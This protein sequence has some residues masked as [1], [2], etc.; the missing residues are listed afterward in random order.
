MIKNGLFKNDEYL[1][2]Y[3]SELEKIEKIYYD[4]D[5]FHHS[6]KHLLKK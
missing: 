1:S 3:Y 2:E 4:I 5:I 6:I